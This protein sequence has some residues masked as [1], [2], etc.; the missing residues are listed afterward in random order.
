MA[1]VPT[2][3][4]IWWIIMVLMALLLCY[5]CW[6]SARGDQEGLANQRQEQLIDVRDTFVEQ[7]EP[8]WECTICGFLASAALSSGSVT[9]ST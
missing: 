6:E 7:G 5:R 4:I 9:G 2:T 3:Y 8:E 1:E